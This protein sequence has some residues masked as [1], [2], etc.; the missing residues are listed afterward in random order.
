MPA[1]GYLGPRGTFTQ[2]ALEAT[3]SGL[4]D[5]LVP[6]STIPGVLRAVEKG[7]VEGGMVPIENSIEGSVNI[8]IDTLAFDSDLLIQREVVYPIRHRLVARPGVRLEHVVGVVSHPHAAAQCRRYLERNFSDVPLT[9][10]NS[11]AEAARRVSDSREQLAAIANSLAAEIYG[12]EVLESHIEDYPQNLSR[13]VV[14]GKEPSAR[15]GSDKTSLV[16]FIQENR[17][18]SLMEILN[19]FASRGINLTKIESRPTRK[20]LGEYY[21]FIDIEG[22][23]QDQQVASAVRSLEPRLRKLKML[24]S[25]PAAEAPPL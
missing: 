14:V 21:F 7:E 25:Y 8:T 15:T 1:V 23:I 9:A 13:F 6:Y 16:C 11:T 24:G 17:P 12:L 5:R 19:E 3:L 22:H 10:A 2:E 4:F 18:G 20:A